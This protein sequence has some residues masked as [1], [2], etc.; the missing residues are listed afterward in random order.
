MRNFRT[1]VIL[2]LFIIFA[3]F[4][5]QFID[6]DKPINYGQNYCDFSAGV[7]SQIRDFGS[8]E[9]T[10]MP[11]LI[12]A[13]SEINFQLTSKNNAEL[14]IQ[15]AWLE[16]KDMYMGKIPLFF[17]A[18]NGVYEANTL[19]GACTEE[20]MNWQMIIVLMTD[21]QQQRLV[22]EFISHQ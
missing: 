4:G 1:P 2:I 20:Q 13:E 19:I 15:S 6:H 14:E 17:S 11:K 16:G 22:F 7:C 8:F 10:T 9:L 5:Y 21:N 3:F 18:K 12:K